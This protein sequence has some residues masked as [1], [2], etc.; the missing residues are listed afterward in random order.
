MGELEELTKASVTPL[1]ENGISIAGHVKAIGLEEGMDVLIISSKSNFL[2]VIPLPEG[3]VYQ[4]RVAMDLDSF[5]LTARN[6]YGKLKLLELQIM[7]STGF[8]PLSD[9]C[10]WEGYFLVTETDKIDK[11]IEWLRSTSSVRDVETIIL[12]E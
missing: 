12:K 7:H 2:R 9:V 4:I 10:L 3:R 6:L 1:K 5:T 8:C 11:F